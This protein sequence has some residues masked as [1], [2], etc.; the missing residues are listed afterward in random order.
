[1][2]KGKFRAVRDDA[3]LDERLR[4]LNVLIRKRLGRPRVVSVPTFA[5]GG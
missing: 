2:A 5:P 1:M 3:L 4:Q